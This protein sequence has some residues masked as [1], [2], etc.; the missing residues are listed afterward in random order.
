[1]KTSQNVGDVPYTTIILHVENV[2]EYLCIYLSIEMRLPVLVNEY[3]NLTAIMNEY[4]NQVSTQM[5]RYI[6]VQQIYSQTRM[7]P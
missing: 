1:M 6:V 7:L 5:F 2:D 4:L 3:K